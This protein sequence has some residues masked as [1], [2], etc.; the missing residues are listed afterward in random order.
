MQLQQERAAAAEKEFYHR[1]AL[2][3]K[4]AAIKARREAIEVKAML[5]STLQVYESMRSTEEKN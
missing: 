5:D 1:N 2:A 3:N 4:E